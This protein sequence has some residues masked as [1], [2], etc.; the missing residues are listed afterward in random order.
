MRRRGCR[1]PRELRGG[2]APL[3]SR[4]HVGFVVVTDVDDILVSLGGSGKPLDP[5]VVG[6]SIACPGNDVD[7]ILARTS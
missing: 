6:A 5:Y 4:V 7:L 1:S 2:C 3:H